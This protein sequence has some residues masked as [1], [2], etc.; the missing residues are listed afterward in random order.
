MTVGAAQRAQVRVGYSPV[1]GRPPPAHSGQA[2][3][4]R[5][6]ADSDMMNPRNAVIIVKTGGSAGVFSPTALTFA[7]KCSSHCTILPATCLVRL[8][9][10]PG[11]GTCAA[12]RTPPG[13]DEECSRRMRLA[14]TVVTRSWKSVGNHWIRISNASTFTPPGP[15][16][17]VDGASVRNSVCT[18]RLASTDLRGD[19]P[20]SP[21]PGH[22]P[23]AGRTWVRCIRN[24]LRP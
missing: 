20:E 4:L 8:A 15:H 7:A 2:A 23:P 13:A 21:L 9:G 18:V 11:G 24:P 17:Q 10:S 19:F 16:S 12:G 22:V 14:I 3:V 5:E 6:N 1:P